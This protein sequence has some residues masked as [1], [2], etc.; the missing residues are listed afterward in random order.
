MNQNKPTKTNKAVDF[1]LASVAVGL[2]FLAQTGLRR[3]A[4]VL[5]VTLLVPVCYLLLAKLF[6]GARLADAAGRSYLLC[7]FAG[8]FGLVSKGSEV[9]YQLLWMIQSDASDLGDTYQT[10]LL[11]VIEMVPHLVVPLMTGVAL[12]TVCSVFESSAEQSHGNAAPL[13]DRLAQWLATSDAPAELKT[14]LAGTAEQLQEIQTH[15]VAL[16]TELASSQQTLSEVRRQAV[17]TSQC[18]EQMA[19]A[20]SRLTGDLKQ[21]SGELVAVGA[22]VDQLKAA[23]SDIDNVVDD[24]SEIISKK[25]LEL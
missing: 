24:L 21:V 14:F 20:G 9:L 13:L 12:F 10:M 8:L 23:V 17:A 3:D 18:F 5:P 1:V 15:Y 11:S 2:I 22:S 7:F 25:I 19:A 4:E 16:N 6:A